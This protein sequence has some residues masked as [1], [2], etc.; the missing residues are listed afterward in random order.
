MVTAGRGASQ[1]L[2][3]TIHAAAQAG[4]TLVQVREPQLD[5]RALLA[6]VREAIAATA[7]TGARVVVNERTDVAL[8]A[9]A[10]GV[11]LKDDAVPASRV[12]RLAPPGFLI[13]RSVHSVDAARAAERD[14]GCD[15]LVFGT[16][17]ASTSKPEGHPAAG[18]EAL[19]RVCRAVRLPVVAIGGVTEAA[20]PSLA[21]ASAAGIAAISFFADSRSAADHVGAV[22]RAFDTHS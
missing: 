17:L 12:R 3:D 1:A 18:L 10:A 8:A 15:Y 19:A 4:L 11:H 21:G 7:G 20:L 13:G 6:L 14:G 9:G 5:D 2:L 16:V 22:R